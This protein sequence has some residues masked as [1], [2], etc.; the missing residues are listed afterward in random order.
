MSSESSALLR[1]NP[2]GENESWEAWGE[3]LAQKYPTPAVTPN[4]PL[5]PGRD[6]LPETWTEYG[7]Q[8]KEHYDTKIAGQP[9]QTSGPA[10]PPLPSTDAT[11]SDWA[12]WGNA[13]GQAWTNYAESK[14]IDLVKVIEG[15]KAPEEPAEDTSGGWTSYA[16]QWGQYSKQ[17]RE[18]FTV[19][20]AAKAS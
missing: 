12:A 10:L 3:R 5:V 7:A 11:G 1:E 20:L 13:V 6:K 19:A 2:R 14:G 4:L 17:V 16:A 15:L 8:W 18:R 9:I